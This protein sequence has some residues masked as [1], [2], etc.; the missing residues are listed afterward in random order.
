MLYPV[1]YPVVS[2]PDASRP[3]EP[4]V[5]RPLDVVRL[6]VP[7]LADDPLLGRGELA[8]FTVES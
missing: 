6:V 3:E 1:G 2:D 4:W 5:G 7:D 8:E